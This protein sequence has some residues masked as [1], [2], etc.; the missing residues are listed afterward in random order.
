MDYKTPFDLFIEC[1]SCGVENNITDY[2]P[3]MRIFCNQCRDQLIDV[4]IVET[5]CEYICQACD[6]KLLLL[7]VTEVKLGESACACGSTNLLEIGETN[8]PEEA[9]KAGGLINSVDDDEILEDTD[10]LRPGG[11]K[12]LGDEDYEDMFN[13]DPGQN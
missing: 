12:D 4:D 3:S 9:A 11:S 2:S 1:R 5:H 6:M 7:K 10:W 8:L 13:Q